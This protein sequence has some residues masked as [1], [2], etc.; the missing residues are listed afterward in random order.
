MLDAETQAEAAARAYGF[1]DGQA[2]MRGLEAGEAEYLNILVE[3][4]VE[5]QKRLEGVAAK[6]SEQSA[7]NQFVVRFL[8]RVAG[9]SDRDA[10][11]IIKREVLKEENLQAL[12]GHYLSCEKL[13]RK[14]LTPR[15]RTDAQK[16]L[17]KLIRVAYASAK[18]FSS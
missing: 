13:L 8:P 4:A 17:S 10:R 7:M 9:N 1:S 5:R 18:K 15:D 16:E 11:A 2:A 12:A 14:S 3:E 6:N